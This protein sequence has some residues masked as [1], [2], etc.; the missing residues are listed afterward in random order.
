MPQL[1][2]ISAGTA[3][4]ATGRQRNVR[5]PQQQARPPRGTTMDCH[6]VREAMFQATDNE[7][8]ADLVAPFRE[9]LS[10]CPDCAHQFVYVGRLVATI[11]E[12]CFRYDAPSTLKMRILS[13][14][15]HRGGVLQE[16]AE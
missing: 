16:V 7:L 9:H 11:R 8:A 3:R 2:G 12:R 10:F 5:S 4:V 15:P 14:F 6:R 13:S 1:T